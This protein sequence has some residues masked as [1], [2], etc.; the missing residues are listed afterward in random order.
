MSKKERGQFYTVNHDYILEGFKRPS[1]DTKII[2][3]FAGKG[4]LL[5]WLGEGY[6]YEAYDIDPKHENVKKRDTLLNPPDYSNAWVITNPPYLAR[7]KTQTKNYFEMYDTNDLYKCFMNS[8]TDC[9]GGIV[10]IPV[11][12]F[13]SPRDIDVRCRD[14]FMTKYTITKIKYFE[15]QVFPDTTTSV[16]AFSFEKSNTPLIE[17]TIEWSRF[18]QGDIKTFTVKKSQKWII[19]GDIYDLMNVK[20]KKISRYVSSSNGLTNLTLNALDSTNNK[21]NLKYDKDFVYKGIHTSRTHA[22]LC[23]KDIELSEEEQIKISNEFNNILNVKRQE[24]WSLFLPQFR[25]FGR[26]RIPFDLAYALV[27]NIIKEMGIN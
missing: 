24:Y 5:S 10:I 1:K 8:L 21:I 26:K 20:N 18:P 2:E 11:G 13:L 14:T 4:D 19:G 6:S 15:E 22:T 27:S 16:V 17:Q 25:E 12:F 3:P 9:L 7:N 23:I